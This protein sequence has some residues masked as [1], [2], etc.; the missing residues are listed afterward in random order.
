MSTR[1]RRWPGST[2]SESLQPVA[3]RPEQGAAETSLN[4]GLLAAKHSGHG[5]AALA[6]SLHL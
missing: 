3:P 5:A 1:L 2:G 4:R 6:G